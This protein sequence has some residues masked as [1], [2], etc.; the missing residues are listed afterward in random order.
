MSK[1]DKTKDWLGENAIAVRVGQGYGGEYADR[2]K[3]RVAM[4]HHPKYKAS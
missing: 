4:P 2:A 3:I 1:Q